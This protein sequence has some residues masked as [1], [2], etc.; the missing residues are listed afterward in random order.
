MSFGNTRT[1]LDRLGVML[2]HAPADRDTRES[3]LDVLN[4]H[5]YDVL[6]QYPWRFMQTEADLLVWQERSYTSTAVIAAMTN[7]SR[8]VNFSATLGASFTSRAPGLTFDDG[9][10]RRF[11]IGAFPTVTQLYLTEA[12]TGGTG[13]N[14]TWS[15]ETDKVQLPRECLQPL[16]YIDRAGERGRLVAISRRKEELYLSPEGDG[17]SGDVWWMVDGDFPVDRPPDST[18]TAATAAGG[19]LTASSIYEYCY[20]VTYEGR[21][22]P[23]SIIVTA[24]TTAINRTI[25]LSGIEN[26]QVGGANTG[27]VKTLYR[28]QVSSGNVTTGNVNGRWLRM[29]IITE[30]STTYSDTGLVTPSADDALAIH[31][32]GPY[33]YIRPRWV[34]GDDATLRVRYLKRPRRL[35]SDAD[36]PEGPANLQKLIV[37]LSAMEIAGTNSELAKSQGWEKKAAD[38]LRRLKENY[39]ETPDRSS[40][41]EMWS[42]APRWGGGINVRGGVVTSDYG[43]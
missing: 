40:Q 8:V 41:K 17:A 35:I 15:I 2:G 20:T 42:V 34:P 33:Q 38:L 9:A 4:S 25:N 36:V 24:T 28:R 10:G 29:D 16:G 21:E 31:Y 27:K 5:L 14:T 32:E 26:V 3:R 39:L 30:A 1:Q 12:Y 11:T 7:G 19:T 22:S 37:L 13:N 43:S 6:E 23:P 18:L